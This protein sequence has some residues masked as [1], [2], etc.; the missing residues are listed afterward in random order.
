MINALVFLYTVLGSNFGL[1]II[2]FTLLTRVILYP[3]SVKQLKST[4]AM[5]SLA[6]RQK[7]LQER[8]KND[9]AR[10]QKE[11]MALFKEAGVSPLGCLGPIFLQLPVF[12]GMFYAVS[13]TLADTPEKLVNLSRALYSWLP[14]GDAAIPLNSSFLGMDL[15]QTPSQAGGV[16]FILLPLLVGGTMWLVQ[17][18]TTT[19]S[20]DPQQQMQTQMMNWMFPMMFGV[21]T[22]NFPNGVALYWITTN[23]LSIALQYRVVGLGGLKRQ[24]APAA[25]VVAA[26]P[27]RPSQDAPPP[28]PPAAQ[29]GSLFKRIFLGSGRPATTP[30]APSSSE[31]EGAA[32]AGPSASG[33]EKQPH[34]TAGNDRQDGR[35]SYRQSSPST[36][37]RPRRRRGGG[38]R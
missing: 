34:A 25:A 18:Q 29:Q 14:G 28:A 24:P 2:V 35:R 23:V 22:I 27:S 7:A 12:I 4:R 26:P 33:Q 10:L 19:P 1:A 16:F 30:S 13:D 6:P 32:G 5:Q 8:F 36:R 17:K 9:R 38:H 15:G 11:Q 21:F 37:G 3:L 20:Q 31:P